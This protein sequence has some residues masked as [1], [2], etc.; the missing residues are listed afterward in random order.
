MSKST[1]ILEAI[2]EHLENRSLKRV[3]FDEKSNIFSFVMN[4]PGPLAFIDYII[5]VHEESFSVLA[6]CPLEAK[7]PAL[8]PVMS[9]FLNRANY[10]LR[11][12][13]FEFDFSDGEVRYK[14]FVDCEDLVPSQ[15]MIQNSISIPLAMYRRYGPGIVNIL[16]TGMSAEQAVRECEENNASS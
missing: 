3:F 13:N 4:L 14:C 11:N 12:G 6:V 8:R 15:K 16:Y 9:E 10:N 5:M 1:R 7:D 2:R